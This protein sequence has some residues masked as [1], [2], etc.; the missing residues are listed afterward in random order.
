MWIKNSEKKEYENNKIIVIERCITSILD[1][2]LKLGT[3]TVITLH[4]PAILRSPVISI[5]SCSSLVSSK[6]CAWSSC[7]S[8]SS[9]FCE[10][11]T[12]SCN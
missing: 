2:D 7:T 4:E 3:K 12:S 11:E 9:T 5:D 1:S 6:S 10:S 8:S